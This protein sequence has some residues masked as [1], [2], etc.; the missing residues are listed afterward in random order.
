MK[1]L[2]R[3]LYLYPALLISFFCG[4]VHPQE[5][6]IQALTTPS[7]VIT[8]NGHPVNFALHGFI[9][10]SSLSELFPYIDSQTHRWPGHPAF[11]DAPA[12]EFTGELLPPGHRESRRLHDRRASLRN[13]LHAHRGRTP[14]RT[15]PSHRTHPGRIRRRLHRRPAKMETCH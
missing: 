9:E 13:T 2:P 12:K 4:A 7:T 1:S 11:D 3:L 14:P 15:C 6:S 8:R 10:F 5:I